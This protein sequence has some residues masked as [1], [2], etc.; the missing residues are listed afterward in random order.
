[1]SKRADLEKLWENLGRW[2]KGQGNGGVPRQDILDSVPLVGSEDH[3]HLVMKAL[4]YDWGTDD[5]FYPQYGMVAT[6]SHLVRDSRLKKCRR[7]YQ[8]PDCPLIREE[9]ASSYQGELSMRLHDLYASNEKRDREALDNEWIPEEVHEFRQALLRR[10]INNPNCWSGITP[11]DIGGY[12]ADPVLFAQRVEGWAPEFHRLSAGLLG[13][14]R[15]LPDTWEGERCDKIRAACAKLDD[16]IDQHW[17]ASGAPRAVIVQQLAA[18]ATITWEEIDLAAPLLRRGSGK[19]GR[20]IVSK[21]FPH[22]G[23]AA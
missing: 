6:W 8:Q 1:M 22:V 5:V 23:G 15:C 12:S 3:L 13:V 9:D 14:P 4:G 7:D 10:E 18:D 20:P 16:T 19:L 11:R 17:I 21:V 2:L